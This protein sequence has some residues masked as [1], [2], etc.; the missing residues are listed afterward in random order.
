MKIGWLVGCS[1]LRSLRSEVLAQLLTDCNET[2]YHDHQQCIHYTAGFQLRRVMC[3]WTFECVCTY[4][5]YT[6]TLKDLRAHNSLWVET[7]LYNDMYVSV[8]ACVCICC[9][10]YLIM[11]SDSCGYELF[12]FKDLLVTKNMYLFWW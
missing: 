4:H 12:P 7:Q 11:F 3:P 6:H 9:G 5:M 2:W 8:R 1:V 10:K